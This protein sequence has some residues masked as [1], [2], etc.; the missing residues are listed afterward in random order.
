[1]GIFC[2]LAIEFMTSIAEIPGLIGCPSISKKS[3]AR[4]GGPLSI[5]FP[6]PLKTRPSMS[7]DTGV[8][9]MSPVNSQTVFLASIPDVPSNTWTTA[10]EPDTSRTFPE[11]IEPSAILT[12]PGLGNKI[13]GHCQDMFLVCLATSDAFIHCKNQQLHLFKQSKYK[14]LGSSATELVER[15]NVL[16]CLVTATATSLASLEGQCEIVNSFEL[17]RDHGTEF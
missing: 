11:R 3:S 17:R 4:I 7:S 13:P 5:G 10:L 9:R 15:R 2:P 12:E 14:L 16:L 6:D 8:L 1:M